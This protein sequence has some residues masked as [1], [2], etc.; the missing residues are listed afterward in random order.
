MAARIARLAR[1]VEAELIHAH[2]PSLNGLAALRAGRRLRLPVVYEI[3]AFWEDSS[4]DQGK[5]Q[6]GSLKYRLSQAVENWLLR[7]VDHVTVICEG[8]RRELLR[9]GHDDRKISLAPNGV[10]LDAFSSPGNGCIRNRYGL[11]GS[12]VLGFIG[13][14]YR[15]EG[16]DLLISAVEAMRETH[17][18]LRLLLVGGGDVQDALHKQMR[19]AHLDDRVIFAGS[20]PPSE[21]KDYY[22]A[23]DV[24]VYPRLPARITEFTTPLKP[25]EAMA[26][27][28]CVVGS[29]VGGIA[30]LIQDR[31]TGFL[32]RAGSRADLVQTLSKVIADPQGCLDVCEQAASWVRQTR[33]WPAIVSRYR[34]VYDRVL[35]RRDVS[36]LVACE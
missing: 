27:R 20:V 11:Q 19:E 9:R 28:K 14:F 7:R 34:A 5:F 18:Q 10:D 29:N 35:C 36:A 17:P 22:A 33:Q 13:S 12:I 1:D 24:L 15:Y 31:Q 3:R 26:L 16:L 4:V 8:I 30:E 23:M 25:L 2:S 32:F 6:A 21:V